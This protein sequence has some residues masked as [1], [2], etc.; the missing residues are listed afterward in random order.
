MRR[1]GFALPELL[2][3]LALAGV[4]AALGAPSLLHVTD[5]RRVES[6]AQEIIYA[7]REARMTAYTAQRTAILRITADSIELRL[8]DRGPDTTL[9]WQRPGPRQFGVEVT[10]SAHTF[11]F[12][13]SGYTIGASNTS[14]TLVL[15]AARRKVVISRLG[16]VR[17][18]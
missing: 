9:L 4:I 8:T 15:G 7:H 17:V 2:L 6:A 3:V 10:G 5:R 13:P 18:E 14:Y 1:N 11:R 16:R 12:I